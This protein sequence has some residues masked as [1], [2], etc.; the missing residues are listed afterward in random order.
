MVLGVWGLGHFPGTPQITGSVFPMAQHIAAHAKQ[1]IRGWGGNTFSAQFNIPVGEASWVG[2]ILT[3]LGLGRL[4]TH[5]VGCNF[6]LFAHLAK[7]L[8]NNFYS[9]Q[10]QSLYALF[11][12]L[13]MTSCLR[14]VEVC[15]LSEDS[16]IKF[17][18]WSL[19]ILFL[20]C[21]HFPKPC[22]SGT[23]APERI[24]KPSPTQEY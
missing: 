11:K 4:R 7:F 3:A 8:C 2:Y 14:P 10:A 15:G 17:N 9:Y 23:R 18:I 6:C 13:E 19:P 22:L 21:F 1:S 12:Y 24:L 16:C 20:S 5:R